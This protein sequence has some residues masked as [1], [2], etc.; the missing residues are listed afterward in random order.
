ML[1][2]PPWSLDQQLAGQL[3]CRFTEKHEN[4]MG[5]NDIVWRHDLFLQKCLEKS[6]LKL[7]YHK[8]IEKNR[9]QTKKI[10]WFKTWNFIKVSAGIKSQKPETLLEKTKTKLSLF[11]AISP[12]GAKKKTWMVHSVEILDF[13]GL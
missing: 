6:S 11:Q 7:T 3:N 2:N 13:V 5:L 10:T 12:C 4:L 1:E 9:G 8:V